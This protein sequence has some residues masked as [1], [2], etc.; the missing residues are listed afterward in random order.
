M[1]HILTIAVLAVLLVATPQLPAAQSKSDETAKPSLD[2]LVNK[3][4]LFLPKTI[5]AQTL[6]ADGIQAE[7]KFLREAQ[8]L[9]QEF[10]RKMATLIDKRVG[11]L[12]DQIDNR[13][14]SLYGYAAYDVWS[15]YEARMAILYLVMAENPFPLDAKTYSHL[16]H[17]MAGMFPRVKVNPRA[18]GPFIEDQRYRAF[19]AA[20]DHAITSIPSSST[21]GLYYGMQIAMRFK[22]RDTAM[23]MARRIATLVAANDLP[24][25]DDRKG[26]DNKYIYNRNGRSAFLAAHAF[27]LWGEPSDAE[28]IATLAGQSYRR[29][30][31]S[32]SGGNN[33]GLY[34][35]GDM[36]AMA[37]A[38]L[39]GET[40]EEAGMELVGDGI[41]CPFAKAA[42][43]FG[44]IGERADFIQRFLKQMDQPGPPQDDKK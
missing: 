13:P 42:D 10:E 22:L 5:E 16:R 28:H 8:A 6:L 30:V 25:V 24:M 38:K 20:C 19:V 37:A 3:Y 4:Q 17:L 15:Q 18:S 41:Y 7:H 36:A 23:T 44:V 35:L 39:A 14:R 43:I 11:E 31:N 26:P 34:P 12:Q 33:P 40:P 1:A 2:S 29:R 21:D 27:H 32:F 9:R